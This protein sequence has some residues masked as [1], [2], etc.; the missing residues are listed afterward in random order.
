ME[1]NRRAHPME[2]PVPC[3]VSAMNCGFDRFSG[4]EKRTL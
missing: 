1:G 2:A 4:D 3:A